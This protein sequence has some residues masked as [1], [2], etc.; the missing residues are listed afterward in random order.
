MKAEVNR[1]RQRNKRHMRARRRL[2]G[3]PQRPRL[4]VCCTLRHIHAQ[5]ID[6][7]AAH[8]LCAA[9]TV[10]PE[11][12]SE[13]NGSTANVQAAAVVGRTVAQRALAAGITK[14]CFDCG[15]RRYHGRVKALAEAAREAGLDF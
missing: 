9:S 8:T 5:V 14:V 7:W 1:K 4:A 2:V 10:E 11:V 13:C 3:T 15:G 12:A 6:D